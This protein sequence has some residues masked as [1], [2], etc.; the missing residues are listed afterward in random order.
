MQTAHWLF[1]FTSEQDRHEWATYCCDRPLQILLVSYSS[2]LLFLR[3][4]RAGPS[5]DTWLGSLTHV[6]SAGHHWGAGWAQMAAA[7]HVH[8]TPAPHLPS[9][10]SLACSR[11]GG[12]GAREVETCKWVSKPLLVSDFCPLIG[13]STSRRQ[14][15]TQSRTMPIKDMG[16]GKATKW[17][18]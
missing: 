15:H 4:L 10:R 12:R 6:R 17:S 9:K 3:S 16:T 8:L 1:G 13:Q 5:A 18:L 14:A 2:H 11:G 7:L